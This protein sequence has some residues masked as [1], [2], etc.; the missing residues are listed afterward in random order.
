MSGRH[1]VDLAQFTSWVP[2]EIRYSDLD[3]QGHVNNAVYFTYFEHAR[4]RYLSAFR[5]RALD[6][7][8]GACERPGAKDDD[9]PPALADLAFVV[10]TASCVYRRPIA[11]LD[12][13]VVG[14]RR[15]GASRASLDLE[16][17][18]CD[19]PHGRLFAT[20][21]TTI[22]SIDPNSGRPRSLPPW[23]WRAGA[24]TSWPS[25]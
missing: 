17:A 5:Q 6:D 9:A 3:T 19:R 24:E 14:V 20:G 25:A 13:I 4:V 23:A 7:V 11:G 18:I 16:Y 22:V 10:A 21:A 15:A 8:R 12:P 1:T 2:I